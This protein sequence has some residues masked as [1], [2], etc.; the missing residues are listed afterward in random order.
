MVPSTSR[1]RRIEPSAL[2]EDLDSFRLRLKCI[3]GGQP[4]EAIILAYQPVTPPSRGRTCRVSN[5]ET[6]FDGI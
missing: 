5:R 1:V 6:S 4:M 2:A 3:R